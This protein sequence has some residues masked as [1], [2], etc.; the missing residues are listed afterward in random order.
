[1]FMFRKEVLIEVMR[2]GRQEEW[3]SSSKMAGVLTI[4]EIQSENAMR[5]HKNTWNNILSIKAE[6]VPTC[7][8]NVKV[9]QQRII[10]KEGKQS[11]S[12]PGTIGVSRL[13]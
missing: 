12:S 4:E 1:M 2:R 10:V 8:K 6:A 5:R 9:C 7:Q 13:W 3:S 11:H